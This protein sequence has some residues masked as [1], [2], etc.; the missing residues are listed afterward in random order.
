MLG[1]DDPRV[2]ALQLRFAET[3]TDGD[4]TGTPGFP[5]RSVLGV[6]CC[7]R[8]A[9]APIGLA[10]LLTKVLSGFVESLRDLGVI[11]S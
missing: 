5:E 4:F 9:Q 2:S 7:G 6:R 3:S 8:L 11:S 10:S 1:R